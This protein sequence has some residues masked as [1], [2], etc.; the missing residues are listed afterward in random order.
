[1]EE[2]LKRLEYLANQIGNL[3]LEKNVVELKPSE[4]SRDKT[5][6]P[7]EPEIYDSLYDA[8]KP[9]NPC[10]TSTSS[11]C[12]PFSTL[13]PLCHYP[14][15]QELLLVKCGPSF[16]SLHMDLFPN[17]KTLKIEFSCHFEAISVSDGKS[18]EELTYLRIGGCGSFVSFPNGGL[19][20]PKL[21]ELDIWLPENMN[22][23]S[24]LKSL[25]IKYCPLIEPLP[26]GEGGLPDLICRDD[27]VVS[28][29]S[30]L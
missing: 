24:S 11:G 28:L 22:S 2:I 27:F 5:S 26:E 20:A 30:I 1:M 12:L 15:L 4:G 16:R 18:L 14:P 25:T 19:I 8:I 3:N 21:N 6:L 23:L 29:Q 7:D 17:L 13:T 9:G 10:S